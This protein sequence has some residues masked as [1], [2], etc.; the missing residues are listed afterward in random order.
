MRSPRRR[1]PVSETEA[2]QMRIAELEAENARLRGEDPK[3]LPSPE[4]ERVITPTESEVIP[5]GEIGEFYVGHRP[6]ADD[7]KPPVTIDAKPEG[8]WT[9]PQ[10]GPP[11]WLRPVP[12]TDLAKRPPASP[13]VAKS[14]AEAERQRQRAN[15]DRSVEHKVMGSARMVQPDNLSSGF[16]WGGASGKRAW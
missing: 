6:A 16:F 5:P 15:S 4:S 7:P 10:D 2:L 12:P 8:S 14:G 13:P 3:A 1:R 11:S 9:G